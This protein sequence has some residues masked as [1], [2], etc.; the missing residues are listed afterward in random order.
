ME[1]NQNPPSQGE[2]L[3]SL[4]KTGNQFDKKQVVE[5]FTDMILSGNYDPLAPYTVLKRMV[6]VA[7]E[8]FENKD[9]QK[10]VRDEAN[11][12][13]SGSQKSFKLYS[14]TICKMAVHTYYDFT[15][16]NHPALA[17][18]Y[19]ILEEV[20]ANI[21]MYEDELKLLIPKDEKKLG[22]MP[23]TKSIVV[24]RMP[25]LK[26]ETNDDQVIVQAPKKIQK[27][28]LKFMKI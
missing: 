26:W 3:A 10:A 19:K 5:T 27:E 18:L 16:C 2:A 6:S 21:K 20:K 8:V 15:G 22:I 11:K 13:L 12:H 1:E 7:E 24:D 28:G 17:E 14:A 23:D 4:V 9:V 25:F